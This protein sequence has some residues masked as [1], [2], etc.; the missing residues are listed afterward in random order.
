MAGFLPAVMEDKWFLFH[1]NDVLSCHRSW[2]GNCIYQ[3]HFIRENGSL[4]ATHAEVNRDEDQYLNTDDEKEADLIYAL[5]QNFL[6]TR[7]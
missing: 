3:I 1:E 2:T 5:I 6:L 4:H 7:Y